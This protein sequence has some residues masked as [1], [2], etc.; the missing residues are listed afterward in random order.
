MVAL[1]DT[2]G[3]HKL[4]LMN[5]AVELVDEDEDG[6]FI[7][8]SPSLTAT[9][10]YLWKC[11]QAD[12][13]AIKKLAAGREITL[14]HLG[15]VCHGVKYPSQLVSTRKADQI[16]IAV[17][18][19]EPW[20]QLPNLRKMRL[21]HGTGAHGF[22]EGTVEILVT[23]QLKA[24]YPSK[25]TKTTR[26]GLFRIAGILIDAAHHGPSAGIRQWTSG[27]V[28]RYYLRSI[29]TTEIV[30]G[31]EPPRIVL[32]AHYHSFCWETVR[33]G[34]ATYHSDIFILPAYCGLSE[35]GQQ[36]TRSKYIISNGLVAFEI[37]GGELADIHRFCRSVDLRTE[38]KL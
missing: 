31:R 6:N 19:F 20:Y 25:D 38:E 17:A 24:K 37:I 29:M 34:G 23:D 35:H 18:N 9:Q 21:I 1:G 3:G 10:K 4:A 13:D 5:P 28:A 11:H 14:L 36:A 7:P 22:G 15:D 27:N 2:H 16:R 12:L 32:R 33:M 30:A 8:Y 26:H